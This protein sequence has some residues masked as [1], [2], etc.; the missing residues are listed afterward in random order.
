MKYRRGGGRVDGA[1]GSVSVRSASAVGR[2]PVV[3]VWVAGLVGP[4]MTVGSF[5]TF[6]YRQSS[7]IA[8]I[9]QVLLGA[10]MLVTQVSLI[11]AGVLVL[12]WL[13]RARR[14]AF[15]D[16]DQQPRITDGLATA[17][18][19]IP[20][21]NLW[22]PA[23]AVLDLVRASD[24]ACRARGGQH[25]RSSWEP[26]VWAWWASWLGAWLTF[27]A[28]SAVLPLARIPLGFGLLLVL[29]ALF[30]AAAAALFTGI[31]RRVADWQ[32]QGTSFSTATASR[33]AP[34]SGPDPVP[35]S[36]A[37]SAPKPAPK[38]A[39]KQALE[40]ATPGS[41][42]R[43][44]WWAVGIGAVVVVVCGSIAMNVYL[45][46]RRADSPPAATIAAPPAIARTGPELVAA[47]RAQ[48]QRDGTG[49]FTYRIGSP[50]DPSTSMTGSFRYDPGGVAVRTEEL[51]FGYRQDS[52][53]LDGQAWQM[54]P[55]GAKGM[56]AGKSWIKCPVDAGSRIDPRY[57]RLPAMRQGFAD[58]AGLLSSAGDAVTILSS[59]ADSINGIP[60]TRYE[61]QVDWTKA[62]QR[63]DQATYPGEPSSGGVAVMML[64]VDAHYRPLRRSATKS[65]VWE[66]TYQD[67]GQPVTILPP[68]SDQVTSG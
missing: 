43:K 31:L 59:A 14:F 9:G 21:A 37:D 20:I 15:A 52:I 10:G 11:V 2:P 48:T 57:C 12:G 68:P 19:F 42:G 63:T 18:W 22:L 34:E 3:A 49:T 17:S 36:P 1:R 26:R 30:M 16:G 50:D 44:W 28:A 23:I 62:R 65:D 67:W 24:P 41:V 7:A 47:M 32:E 13:A 29:F 6:G 40:S 53:V 5:P 8:R 55:A 27:W 4:L 58:P 61:L 35:Q 39:L 64:W 66:F 56:P 60:A 46:T 45:L 51:I 54:P 38:P 25:G 33:P